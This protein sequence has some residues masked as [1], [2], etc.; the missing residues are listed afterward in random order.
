[1]KKISATISA[2]A[3]GAVLPIVALAQTTVGGRTGQNVTELFDIVARLASR[4]IGILVTI[5]LAVFFWGLVRYLFKLGGEKGAE[6]GKNLMIYGLVALFVM[7]SVWGILNF[8]SSFFGINSNA[9]QDSS[10]LIPVDRLN[11]PR[12]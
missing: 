8:V 5:A 12:S 3:L 2:F 6:N 1:M 4:S 9:N 11:V 7:I 10:N